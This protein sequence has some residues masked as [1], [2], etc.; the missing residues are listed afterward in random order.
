GDRM[1]PL[2]MQG[3]KKISDLLTDDA[4]PAQER[5]SVSVVCSGSTI[6]WVVGYRMAHEFRVTPSTQQYARLYYEQD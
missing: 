4:V 1:R 3:T 6:A 2:G 5:S